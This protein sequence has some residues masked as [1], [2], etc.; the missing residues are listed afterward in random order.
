MYLMQQIGK[1]G[2]TVV[3]GTARLLLAAALSFGATGCGGSSEKST[4]DKTSDTTSVGAVYEVVS[5]AE[6]TA[7]LADVTAILSTLATLRQTSE[8]DARAAV[9]KMYTRWF[10][11]EGTIRNNDKDLYLQMEDGLV[12][13]KIGVQEDRPQKLSDGIA[14]FGSAVVKYAEAHP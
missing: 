4:S 8:A 2:M 13:A 3:R 5:D 7:G 11:F 1:N 10:E 6:V 9:E 12:G 14:E